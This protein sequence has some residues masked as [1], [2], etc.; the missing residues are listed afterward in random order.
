[1]FGTYSGRY[2][3]KLQIQR[4]YVQHE[5]K[6]GQDNKWVLMLKRI[7]SHKVPMQSVLMKK[8][9]HVMEWPLCP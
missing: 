2:F 6:Y 9:K 7:R 4:R 3:T 5:Y 1:M 8:E